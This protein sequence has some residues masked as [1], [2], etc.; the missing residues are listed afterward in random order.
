MRTVEVIVVAG[1]LALAFAALLRGQDPAPKAVATERLEAVDEEDLIASVKAKAV[2]ELLLAAAERERMARP[3]P[4]IGDDSTADPAAAFRL[5]QTH[6]K[7]LF[8]W[9]GTAPHAGIRAEFAHAIHCC[10]ASNA[11]D[12]TPRLLV[13][14]VGAVAGQSFLR[15]GESFGPTTLPAIRK[16][17]SA[18]PADPLSRKDDMIF[19]RIA[20]RIAALQ[21]VQN[22]TPTQHQQ[23]QA[24]APTTPASHAQLQTAAANVATPS[25]TPASSTPTSTP[26]H[27]FLDL[28]QSFVTNPQE[29]ANVA[30]EIGTIVALF[31]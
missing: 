1:L 14:P 15:E 5:A 27:P 22:L 24:A 31:K 13:F 26:S 2:A 17:V 9:I 28:L 20:Q 8:V 21:T 10:T 25:S 29:M 19:Q 3:K 6:K 11:G 18:R 30:S 4:A 16:L 23:L 12:A 7:P